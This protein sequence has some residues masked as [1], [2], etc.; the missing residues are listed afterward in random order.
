MGR[1]YTETT[2][3]KEGFP[4]L[5]WDLGLHHHW[6]TDRP[7]FSWEIYSSTTRLDQG[8]RGLFGHD[9][10]AAAAAAAAPLALV[11]WLALIKS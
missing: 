5:T 8:E 7:S 10:I 6:E 11:D 1:D 2:E 3:V 4:G 9:M